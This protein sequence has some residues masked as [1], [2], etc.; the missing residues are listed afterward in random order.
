ME[1]SSTQTDRGSQIKCARDGKREITA[2]G[3]GGGGG[4]ITKFQKTASHNLVVTD[5]QGIIK[6]VFV[7]QAMSWKDNE[8]GVNY[9][10]MN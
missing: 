1:H 5:L 3:V 7:L 9:S 8:S 10:S 4:H 2:F 6:S